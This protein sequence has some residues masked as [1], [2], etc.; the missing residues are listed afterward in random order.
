MKIKL[1]DLNKHRNETTFRPFIFL[2]ENFEE[3]G[4]KFVSEGKADFAFVAQASIIDKKLSLKNSIEYG[5][6]FLSQVK[7]PYFLFD[8]Q[9]STSLIGTY[10]V[11]K[12]SNAIYLFKN[13]LLKDRN[14][15]K[16]KYVNGRYFW[17]EGNYNCE[18]F[19]KY[20]SKILLSGFNWLNTYGYDINLMSYNNKKLYDVC[21]L[22]GLSK[23]NLEHELRTDEHYNKPRYQLFE[24]IKKLKCNVVTTEKTGKL[25][26][27]QYFNLLSNSKI[28]ISPYGYGEI[29]I[30]DIEAILAGCLIIKPDMSFV[31]T[32]PNIYN[33]DIC[34][35]CKPDYSDLNEKIEYILSNY[36]S[37][38]EKYYFNIKK[39]INEEFSK[40]KLIFKYYNIFKNLDG[41]TT[42]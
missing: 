20:E 14:L 5:L 17:G 7:E 19:E 24:E 12:Q 35:F 22:I 16:N 26:K 23:E 15:Y 42:E 1:L 41:I 4:V 27:S 11:F 9:D 21:C 32:S 25:E 37:L 10:D 29:A 13:N 18:D 30:R 6:N 8:G 31:D 33:E 36:N 3:I 39:N 2:K 28:C 40:N 38:Y 34:V